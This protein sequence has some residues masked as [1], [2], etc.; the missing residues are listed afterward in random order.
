[1]HKV[2]F[3]FKEMEMEMKSVCSVCWFYVC[4]SV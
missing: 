3:L 2:A 4:A 1:M